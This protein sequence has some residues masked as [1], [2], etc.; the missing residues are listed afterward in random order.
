[1][2]EPVLPMSRTALDRL[3]A[4]L[5]ASDQVGNDDLEHLA[6]V[7]DAY[8]RVLDNVKSHLAA[9]GFEATT[10]VKTTITLLE[11]LRREQRM[12]LKLSRVQDLAGARII[13][14]DR[15]AQD[16]ARDKISSHFEAAGHTIRETDRRKD[17]S[18]GYRALHMIVQVGPIPVEI[19]IRTELEDTWAQI[20]ERLGD[21]WGRDIRYGGEPDRPDARVRAG[22]RVMSRQELM[23]FVIGLSEPIARFEVTR[24][25][26]LTEARLLPLFY[27]LMMYV[28]Q[29]EEAQDQR[30]MSERPAEERAAADIMAAGLAAAPLPGIE[31]AVADVPNMTFAQLLGVISQALG[32]IRGETEEMLPQ[33]RDRERE[34]R[35][36][37]QLIEVATDEG[38]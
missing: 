21:A 34:L 2:P 4:R 10:R 32:S 28:G 24:A 16:D 14:S 8:Q 19:Q 17:P 22:K 12:N 26:M 31:G 20:V 6:L 1:V 27:R 33:L 25:A 38:D 13:V 36:T 30:R 11:K 35:D 15:P 18:F 7:V 5:G 37:L 9:L 29:F 23:A 3:G